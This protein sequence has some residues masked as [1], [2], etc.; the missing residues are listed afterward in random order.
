MPAM[1]ISADGFNR[2][3]DLK[4]PVTIPSPIF[5]HESIVSRIGAEKLI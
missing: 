5:S 4:I 2:C 1:Q 3:M